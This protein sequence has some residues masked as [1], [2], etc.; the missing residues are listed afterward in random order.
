MRESS[1]DG[2]PGPL[3]RV[4]S[5]LPR[6]ASMLTPASE[7]IGGHLLSEIPALQT[8]KNR[9]KRRPRV[10]WQNTAVSFLENPTIHT[11]PE[12]STWPSNVTSAG[13]V[14][15]NEPDQLR[16]QQNRRRFSYRSVRHALQFQDCEGPVSWPSRMGLLC[17]HSIACTIPED[18]GV[19]APTVG[20]QGDV[21]SCDGYG[22]VVTVVG[23]SGER[24]TQMLTVEDS[25]RT[26]DSHGSPNF[27]SRRL[28]SPQSSGFS[29]FSLGSPIQGS[30]A[31]VRSGLSQEIPV[32][33]RVAEPT[34]E[35]LLL[36]EP[37]RCSLQNAACCAS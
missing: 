36:P 21:P 25:E 19:E 22:R 6:R 23:G 8:Y 29:K 28:S 35:V 4:R 31:R 34:G 24:R 16:Q 30:L 15:V 32:S 1:E 3:R 13:A 27:I 14:P 37:D 5:M 10:R 2:S 20:F 12:E 9:P 26:L 17:N 33:P 18:P 7:C 11:Y